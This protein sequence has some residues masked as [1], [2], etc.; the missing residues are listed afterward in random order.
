VPPPAR[1]DRRAGNLNLTFLA[2]SDTHFGFDVSERNLFGRL[3]DPVK[4]PEGVEAINLASITDMNEI[5]AKPWPP[6]L[7]GTIGEPRGLLISGDL[8][9]NGEA[10][11]W[12]HFAAFYGL[13]GG[14]GLLRFPVFE[15]HGN[16]DKHRSWYVLD[17]VRERHGWMHYS[18]DWDDLYVACLGEAPDDAGL[19][20]LETDLATAGRER[21][22]LVYFHFPL[23]GPYADDHWFGRG[24]YRERLRRTLS[25]YNVVALFHGHYHASGHYRWHGWDVYNVGAAKHAQHSFAVVHVSDTRL[26]VASWQFQED[27]WEWWHDK[28]INGANGSVVQGGTHAYSRR[29][30]D[31][32]SGGN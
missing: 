31:E 30:L 24:N 7:G 1:R 9:E 27:R 5:A 4:N 22:V 21:P 32:A 13:K 6:A 11:Q 15:G 18:F 17:R 26:R 29:G 3:R 23:L 14:D 2:F 28:P 19:R 25:G 16:H 12:R 20:W 10:W 8:T